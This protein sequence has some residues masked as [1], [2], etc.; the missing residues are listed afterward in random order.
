MISLVVLLLVC[1]VSTSALK[2]S[3]MRARSG[4]SI[5]GVKSMNSV[6]PIKNNMA[7][8]ATAFFLP[9]AAHA[10]DGVSLAA[11]STPLIVSFLTIIPFIYYTTALKPKDRKATQIE[12]DEY[13]REVKGKKGRK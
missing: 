4:L 8:V 13:N 1:A 7:G 12:V 5:G 9:N 6:M 11:F 2:F 10:A 3:G